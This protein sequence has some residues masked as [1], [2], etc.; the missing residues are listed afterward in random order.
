MT[1]YEP[2]LPQTGG[3]VGEFAGKWGSEWRSDTG[4]KVNLKRF[5]D[6]SER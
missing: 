1:E 3:V 4:T 5:A 6:W 2:K